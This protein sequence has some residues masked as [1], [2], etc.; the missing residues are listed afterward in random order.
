[1]EQV[2]RL[3]RAVDDL[4]QR[5][6]WLAFPLAVAKEYGEDQGGQEPEPQR[7]GPQPGG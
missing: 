1:M 2:K 5:H 3:V 7:P 6:R 4:Q